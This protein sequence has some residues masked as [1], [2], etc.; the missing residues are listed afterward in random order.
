MKCEISIEFDRERDI[1]TYRYRVSNGDIVGYVKI[2]CGRNYLLITS[3][4]FIHS[5]SVDRHINLLNRFYRETTIQN[6]Y[7][8]LQRQYIRQQLTN[9]KRGGDLIENDPVPI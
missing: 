6:V 9:S 4:I 2:T 5:D 3:D 8:Y 1:Y 7:E